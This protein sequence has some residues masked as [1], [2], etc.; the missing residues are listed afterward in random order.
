[1]SQ[2]NRPSM[3][4]GT[5]HDLNYPYIWPRDLYQKLKTDIVRWLDLLLIN[6]SWS[7]SSVSSH[8]FKRELTWSVYSMTKRIKSRWNKWRLLCSKTDLLWVISALQCMCETDDNWQQHCLEIVTGQKKVLEHNL[9]S[10][11]IRKYTGWVSR[12]SES[13]KWRVD[14]QTHTLFRMKEF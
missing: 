2:L 8:V 1:M 4:M 9:Q 7:I 12:M 10:M 13:S 5:P 14:R 11:G 6:I 3:F